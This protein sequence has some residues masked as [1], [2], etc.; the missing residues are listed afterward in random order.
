MPKLVKEAEQ[1]VTE[2][3]THKWK[4]AISEEMKEII[5][6]LEEY[7]GDPKDLIG[8]QE[9]MCHMV[10]HIKLTENFRRKARFVADGR[11]T[12]T[13]VLVTYSMVVSKDLVGIIFL[14]AALNDLDL[15]EADIKNAFLTAPSKEKV[16][17]RAG[18]EFGHLEGRVF[19][20]KK[21]LYGLKAAGASFR[22][23]FTLR[24]DECGFKSSGGDPDVWLRPAV[25]ADGEEFYEYVMSYVD[26][27][28]A[29]SM[30][31]EATLR[32]IAR[33]TFKYK[34]DVVEQP[35]SYLGAKNCKER[36]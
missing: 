5:K 7:N 19:I 11:K 29:V 31:A 34:N 16:W 17:V 20:V 28:I 15:K 14:L 32:D 1:I 10:F 3:K 36:V 8:Y 24:L 35:T 22:S 18:P 27:V 30:D 33:D 6:A 13:P 9:I 4:D 12:K 25:K 23:C 21:A 26:N 2:N